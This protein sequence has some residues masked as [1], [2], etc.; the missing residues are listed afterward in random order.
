MKLDIGKIVD[1]MT[2]ESYIPTDSVKS[3]NDYSSLVHSIETGHILIRIRPI[4]H[5]WLV[6]VMK[7]RVDNI[8]VKRG[9]SEVWITIYLSL[10]HI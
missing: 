3:D 2:Q 1:H 10:I 6:R 8:R 4:W 9:R 7:C 5:T